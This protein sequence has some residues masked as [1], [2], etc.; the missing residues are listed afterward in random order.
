M[1]KKRSDRIPALPLEAA[2]E[3]F[4]A[5]A[6]AGTVIPQWMIEVAVVAYQ[7]GRY[8]EASAETMREALL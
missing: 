4:V 5:H 8:D 6:P 2:Y 3:L 7:N 1:I